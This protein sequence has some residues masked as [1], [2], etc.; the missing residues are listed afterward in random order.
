[1]ILQWC[2]RWLIFIET[3]SDLVGNLVKCCGGRMKCFES[4][5]MF[6]FR[7]VECDVG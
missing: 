7:D 2:V 5:L 4:V 3:I 1:M 6:Y